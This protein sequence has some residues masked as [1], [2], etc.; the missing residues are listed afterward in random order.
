MKQLPFVTKANRINFNSYEIFII[1]LI[2][3]SHRDQTEIL[4]K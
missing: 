2:S 3:Q 4:L 1:V